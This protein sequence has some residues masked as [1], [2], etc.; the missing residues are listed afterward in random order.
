MCGSYS[1]IKLPEQH[2]KVL[3]RVLE[4]DTNDMYVNTVRVCQ[5]MLLWI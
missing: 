5:L 2:M 1:T 4:K 3:E